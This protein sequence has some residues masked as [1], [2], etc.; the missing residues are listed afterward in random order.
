MKKVIA[1]TEHVPRAGT[2]LMWTLSGPTDRDA[3]RDAWIAEGLD[4]DDLPLPP[5]PAT[6]L[7]RA[8]GALRAKRRIVQSIGKNGA[9]YA[10]VDVRASGDDDLDFEVRCKARLDMVGRL[11][12]TGG[13]PAMQDEIKEAFAQHEAELSTEDVSAW[14][15]KRVWA[16]DGVALRGGGGVYFIPHGRLNELDEIVMALKTSSTHAIYRIPAMAGDDA[17]QAILD[18]VEAEAT[19]EAEQI[20]RELTDESFGARGLENRIA[21][22]DEVEEKVA[23]YEALL[24]SKLET[25]RARLE[26]LRGDL[27]VAMLKARAAEAAEEGAA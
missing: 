13:T 27:T 3:L 19:A 2:I 15:T 26:R 23:R 7:R 24:G 18:A 25:M 1:V 4:P 12:V 21:K 11:Q 14:L 9:G 22:T 6:V 8:V 5:S 10:L 16:L 20:E 17:V